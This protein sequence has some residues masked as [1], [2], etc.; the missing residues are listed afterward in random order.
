M[1]IP[2][3]PPVLNTRYHNKN[4]SPIINSM[5][6]IYIYGVL[7]APAEDNPQYHCL[8][9]VLV[10]MI[11]LNLYLSYPPIPLSNNGVRKGYVCNTDIVYGDKMLPISALQENNLK[12]IKD[13]GALLNNTNKAV[14]CFL[15]CYI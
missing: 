13:I 12:R 14:I 10:D 2:L 15:P 1:L 3:P 4:I 5:L 6:N 9:G 8:I 7:T 11:T